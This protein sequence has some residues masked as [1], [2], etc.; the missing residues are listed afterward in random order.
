MQGTVDPRVLSPTPSASIPSAVPGATAPSTTP[1]L[2]SLPSVPGDTSGSP[3]LNVP[4][5]GPN[6]PLGQFQRWVFVPPRAVT[7][8]NGQV[9]QQPGFWT[10]ETTTGVLVTEHWEL[11]QAPTGEL[12]WRMVPR[13]F[14]A[15]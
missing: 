3:F 14:V 9:F 8:A 15:R 4:T 13:A 7:A 5:F 2:G 11:V 6:S 1:G 10:A 12:V